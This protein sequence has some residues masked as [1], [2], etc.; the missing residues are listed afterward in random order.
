MNLSSFLQDNKFKRNLQWYCNIIVFIY[1]MLRNINTI[2]A[3]SSPYNRNVDCIATEKETIIVKRNLIHFE[4]IVI[5]QM[6]FP[7]NFND[8]DDMKDIIFQ[9]NIRK[10]RFIPE[11]EKKY[12]AATFEYIGEKI[13]N[14][15]LETKLIV[16]GILILL[17]INLICCLKKPLDC[18]CVYPYYFVMFIAKFVTCPCGVYIYLTRRVPKKKR[19]LMVI[20][21][22]AAEV[23]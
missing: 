8:Q 1:F 16:G 17:F 4:V 6:K 3:R 21:S 12:I 2:E 23:V 11:A 10:R 13:K 19:E 18:L 22:K 5:N 20:K 9:R 14:W 7:K 15:S